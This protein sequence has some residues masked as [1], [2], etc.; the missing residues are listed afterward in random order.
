MRH[1][2]GPV[3]RP[4]VATR[5]AARFAR[6]G[7]RGSR[8]SISLSV[9]LSVIGCTVTGHPVPDF[10]D[11]AALD[12]GAYVTEPLTEPEV[13]DEAYGRVVES[14]RMAESAVRPVEVDAALEH[15]FGAGI[16][17]LPTPTKAAALLADPVA[18]VLRR[19]GMLAGVAVNGSDND[20]RVQPRPGADRFL[21]I[22]LFRFPDQD[23]AQR[24]AREIDG[25]DA[26]VSRENIGVTIPGHPAAHAHRRPS[27]PTMAATVAHGSF[28]V[29]LLAG[30]DTPDLG[31][32]TSLVS[33]AFD[34]QLPRLDE[35]APTPR[36][37]LARLPLD[38]TGMLG[39]MVPQ[40]PGRWPPP[41][42]TLSDTDTVAGWEHLQASGVVFGPR[43]GSQF[44]NRGKEA[45]PELVAVNGY[46][47]L[48]RH[49]DS[50]SARAAY[51]RAVAK[52]SANSTVRSE[53][54][55]TDLPDIH[56]RRVLGDTG[57]ANTFCWVVYG[58]YEAVVFGRV[59]DDVR[60]K[61]FAQ[62]GLLLRNG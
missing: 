25:E 51:A 31:A 60:H 57:W 11:P 62:L 44:L 32:L 14:V 5:V 3:R 52:Q 2:E 39:L 13:D 41:A 27:V 6:P 29:S 42:V 7:R 45:S 35:F 24:A 40:A 26:A 9:L 61:A 53:Q 37:E 43:G 55:A 59:A 50:A 56:C 36:A 34:R 15:G 54:V 46:N 21:V 18:G 49:H 4:G 23:A 48:V 16:V 1:C 10:P 28:V 17:P 8:L 38:R 33:G 12:T 20:L 58:R 19:H 47:I 22:T 30:H